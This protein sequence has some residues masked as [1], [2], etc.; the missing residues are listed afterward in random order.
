MG[1]QGVLVGE[2]VEQIGDL[3]Q[4]LEHEQALLC[5]HATKQALLY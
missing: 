5:Q 2:C 3:Q 1:S 4:H